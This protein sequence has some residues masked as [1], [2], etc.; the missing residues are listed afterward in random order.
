MGSALIDMDDADQYDAYLAVVIRR[1]ELARK[2][3]QQLKR[4]A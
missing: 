2:L 1:L 4:R 3:N